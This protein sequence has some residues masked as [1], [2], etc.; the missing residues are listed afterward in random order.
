MT[1]R[2]ADAASYILSTMRSLLGLSLMANVGFA[3][4]HASLPVAFEKNAVQTHASV[5]LST[6]ILHIS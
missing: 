4:R 1:G 5:R 2:L 3:T 6:P